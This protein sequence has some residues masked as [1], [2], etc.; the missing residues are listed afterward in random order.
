MA[1]LT[2]KV[3][4]NDMLMNLTLIVR[5]SNNAAE[6]SAPRGQHTQLRLTGLD[7]LKLAAFFLCIT[8]SYIKGQHA[9]SPTLRYKVK[10]KKIYVK[11]YWCYFFMGD[12]N[13]LVAFYVF[14]PFVYKAGPATHCTLGCANAHATE[15]HMGSVAKLLASTYWV[16]F[17]GLQYTKVMRL[18]TSLPLLQSIFHL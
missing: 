18:I 2:I 5:N 13:M 15:C 11:I 16:T 17:T 6:A 8:S 9:V 3:T 10:Q 1:H 14:C 7:R 12:S 4:I